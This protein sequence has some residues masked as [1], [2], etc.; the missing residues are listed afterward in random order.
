MIYGHIVFSGETKGILKE[1]S[2]SH[3][4]HQPHIL[5]VH[6]L[7]TDVAFY[8]LKNSVHGII[9]EESSFATHGANILRCYYSN[10]KNVIVWVSGVR[11]TDIVGLLGKMV[12]ITSEGQVCELTDVECTNGL[13]NN[14]QNNITYVPLN[15]RSIVSYNISSDSYDICYWPHRHF[16]ILTFSIMK[17]GLGN[18]LCMLG[19]KEIYIYLDANGNIWFRNAPLICE[20]IELAKNHKSAYPMLMNQIEMYNKIYA[21]LQFHFTFS[22]LIGMLIDYFSIFILFHDTYED[23]LVSADTF[24]KEHMEPILVYQMMNLLMSCKLDE[25]MLDNN[26]LLEK[27]KN[28]LSF[29][30]LAPIP[31]FTI[32]MDISYCIKRFYNTLKTLG[33]EKF[34]IIHKERLIF[35]IKFF[36]AKEWKFV[37]NKILFTRFSDYVRRRLPD[38]SFANLSSYNF[39]EVEKLMGELQDE[40]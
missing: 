40:Y 18:N 3:T 14:V 9:S 24:F 1:Y 29:E 5:Y 16:N 4:E 11:R 6:T 7:T 26:I 32:I 37:M 33:Y 27:Q 13:A 21:Q 28:L 8:A 35:Y 38:I 17:E 39:F 15:K 25:W 12:Y 19:A 36:V 20:L 23:V 22:Q 10:S 30:C 31:E 2:R 34:W